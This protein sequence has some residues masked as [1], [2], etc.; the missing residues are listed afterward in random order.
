MYQRCVLPSLLYGSE[1]WCMTERDLRQHSTFHTKYVGIT[2]TFSVLLTSVYPRWCI[3][4]LRR[5][6]IIYKDV[7]RI[8]HG[9]AALHACSCVRCTQSYMNVDAYDPSYVDSP[10]H[11]DM[12]TRQ[13]GKQTAQLQVLIR[14]IISQQ[15]SQLKLVCGNQGP[16]MPTR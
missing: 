1:C 10:L 3:R 6:G 4:L 8:M 7:N 12:T 16:L 13:E 2:V 15:I 14:D 11:W 5:M 9:P